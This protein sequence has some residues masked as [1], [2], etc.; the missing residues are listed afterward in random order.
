[1]SENT[2]LSILIFAKF[3]FLRFAG[4]LWGVTKNVQLHHV[5]NGQADPLS[6]KKQAKRGVYH[7]HFREKPFSLNKISI[8]AISVSC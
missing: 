1:M 8:V 2:L 5:R 6:E 7:P 4:K 3:S